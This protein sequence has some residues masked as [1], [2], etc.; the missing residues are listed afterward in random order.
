MKLRTGQHCVKPDIENLI[1]V[2]P[3]SSYYLPGGRCRKGETSR[4][5]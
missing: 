2:K 5:E 1:R 3:K 4:G